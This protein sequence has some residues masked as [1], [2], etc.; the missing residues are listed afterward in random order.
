MGRWGNENIASS[1]LF[2]RNTIFL[3]YDHFWSVVRP[4]LK[5]L[6][7]FL[8]NRT[9]NNILAFSRLCATCLYIDYYMYET[10]HN[11]DP[12]VFEKMNGLGKI[13]FI[14]VCR[15]VCL[16]SDDYWLHTS[17]TYVWTYVHDT[18]SGWITD[19]FRFFPMNTVFNCHV[20]SRYFKENGRFERIKV[21]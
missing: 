3:S 9:Y 12:Q 8:N 20:F 2:S 7:I 16:F 17:L 21:C 19:W 14:F 4:N 11:S 6:L 13:S 10:L 5:K 1:D 18:S 15:C